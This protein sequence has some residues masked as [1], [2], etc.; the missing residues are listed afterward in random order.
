MVCPCILVWPLDYIPG[1]P[2][3]VE[4]KNYLDKNIAWYFTVSQENSRVIQNI[5]AVMNIVMYSQI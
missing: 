1:I 3:E 2:C 4:N 5:L